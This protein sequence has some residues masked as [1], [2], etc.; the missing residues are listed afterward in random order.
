M[1]YVVILF[2]VF[3]LN[4]IADTVTFQ[5]GSAEGKDAYTHLGKPDDNFGSAE[6]LF[7][8]R[9]SGDAW[10]TFIEFTQLNSA[11]YQGVHVNSASLKI[12]VFYVYDAGDYLIGPCNA[13]WDA[14][15]ITWNTNV[16]TLETIRASY[17]SR[18]G[19][20]TYDVTA[21]VQ[22]WLN[23]TWTNNGFAISDAAGSSKEAVEA[24]SSNEYSPAIHPMLVLDYG[25]SSVLANSTWAR[26]K[27]LDY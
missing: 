6:A 18:S 13:S 17:P 14:N 27:S 4:A 25:A 26:I 2:L 9:H 7:W 10:C 8:G 11:K 1:R 12:F 20:V 24:G 16:G 5:P 23:G 3:V 19:W 15:T 22:K 21:W